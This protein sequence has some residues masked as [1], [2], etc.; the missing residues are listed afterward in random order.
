MHCAGFSLAEETTQ[1]VMWAIFASPY[2]MSADPRPGRP[3]SIRA[4]ESPNPK[5]AA[6]YI[7]QLTCS[8]L[9]FVNGL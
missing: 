4:S 3:S 2:Y 5:P 8:L 7:H 9:F 1:M 6:C